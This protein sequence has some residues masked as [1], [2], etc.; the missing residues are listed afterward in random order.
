[1]ADDSRD[2]TITIALTNDLRKIA[3]VAARIDEYCSA[4]GVA[5]ETVYAINLAVDELLINTISHGYDDDEPHRIE[6][7]L[8]LEGNMVVVAIV[9]DSAPFDPT[10]IGEPDI[11]ALVDGEE[12]GGREM[13]GLGLLLVNRTMDGV[14][15][16]RRGG[17]NVVTL[18]K[19]MAGEEGR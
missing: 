11:N 3:R 9:D 10:E 13:E 5:P 18:T 16:R 6:V 19:N 14:E 17:C 2:A 1:M 4:R 7:I 15:Y 12:I 8:R